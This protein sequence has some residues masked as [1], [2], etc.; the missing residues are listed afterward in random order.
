LACYHTDLYTFEQQGR[1]FGIVGC[2]VG[3]AF[4]VLIAEELFASGCRLLVSMTSAG[5]ITPVQVPPYFVV[6][7]R[8]LR[9]YRGI[10][11]LIETTVNR[12]LVT[13]AV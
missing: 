12:S 7:D 5:Q 2:A 10:S 3:G 11:G 8:A 1:Q 4:A 6:I 9:R 13:L